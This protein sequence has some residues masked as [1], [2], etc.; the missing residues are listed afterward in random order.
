MEC[1]ADGT[2]YLVSWSP[3]DGFHIDDDVERGPG[4]VARVEAEPGDDVDGDDLHYE[5]R[6]TGGTPRAHPVPDD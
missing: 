1:R 4:R 6:C 2:V 5:V 3:A